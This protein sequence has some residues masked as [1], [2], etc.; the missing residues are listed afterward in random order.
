[1]GPLHFRVRGSTSGA[2]PRGA[3][4]FLHVGRGAAPLPPRR[5]PLWRETPKGPA[6][7]LTSVVGPL[8][9]RHVKVSTLAQGPEEPCATSRR[10]WGRSTAWHV[11]FPLFAQGPE[12]PC[13][14]FHGGCGAAPLP[15]RGWIFC[16][17]GAAASKA[18]LP[19]P[20]AT[21][22]PCCLEAPRGNGASRQ[23]AK[24]PR[25]PFASH[26]AGSGAAPLPMTRRFRSAELPTDP[27]IASPIDG[28]SSIPRDPRLLRCQPW[29]PSPQ[30][31]FLWNTEIGRAHV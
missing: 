12:E 9:F 16:P 30:S 18:L 10:P 29:V 26:H 20:A 14:S 22:L 23:P 15:S 2:G 8:H 17:A 28:W 5:D 6:L 11:K 4:R 31:P 13:A 27:S 19:E 21:S 1:M 24:G 3:L 25:G 7:S